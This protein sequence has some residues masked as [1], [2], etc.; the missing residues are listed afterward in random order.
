LPPIKPNYL[1]H[2]A[3]KYIRCKTPSESDLTKFAILL[4][5][6]LHYGL[7][8]L[9]GPSENY[10]K[11]KKVRLPEPKDSKHKKILFM[12]LDETLIHT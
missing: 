3:F 8:C 9:K 4:Y 12:D 5:R 6:G 7:K 11:K 2:P 1:A 10:I